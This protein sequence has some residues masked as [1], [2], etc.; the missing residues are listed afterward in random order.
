MPYNATYPPLFEDLA[1][2]NIK[3]LTD[4]GCFAQHGQCRST[5]KWT[6]R[7]QR[8]AEVGFI[9]YHSPDE[10][11]LS[12][13]YNHGPHYR[14]YRI[15]IETRPSNLGKGVVRYFRCPETDLLCRK[16]YLYDGY[17]VHRK[18]IPGGCYDAQTH[19]ETG[20]LYTAFFKQDE[21]A[22][23]L[24]KR[25]AKQTY[26]GKPTARAQR[27]L[28]KLERTDNAMK[29]TCRKLLDL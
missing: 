1:N 22:E 28:D 17:F 4:W 6:C 7:G 14:T 27:L 16:L 13:Q 10:T 5:M 12:L 8:Y 9:V 19:S 25:N 26:R 2:L 18:G 29:I 24:Y 15:P 23:K 3:T 20:R 21:V 11:Y